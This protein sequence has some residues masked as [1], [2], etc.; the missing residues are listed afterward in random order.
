MLLIGKLLKEAVAFQLEAQLG[1]HKLDQ[2]RNN[3]TQNKNE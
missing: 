1:C 2:A 3:E